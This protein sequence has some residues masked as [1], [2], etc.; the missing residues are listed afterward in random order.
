MR[1]TLLILFFSINIVSL[2][3]DN[4]FPYS[5]SKLEFLQGGEV[6]VTHSDTPNTNPLTFFVKPNWT[7][8]AE[9]LY[10][11]KGIKRQNAKGVAIG[12]SY[13]IANFP[14]VNSM[15]SIWKEENR[16]FVSIIDSNLDMQHITE[17][18]GN[19]KPYLPVSAYWIGKTGKNEY[20]FVINQSFYICKLLNEN[21]ISILNIAEDV[22][23]ATSL[24][25]D[26]DTTEYKAAFLVYQGASW[27]VNFLK[28]DNT[29]LFSARMPISDKIFLEPFK[30]QAA[31]ITYSKSYPNSLLKIVSPVRG[32][33]SEIWVKTSGDKIKIDYTG[34]KAKLFYLV[35]NNQQYYL[36]I[37]N[38]TKESQNKHNP[39]IEIPPELIEP[40]SIKIINN[41]IVAL[42]RNGIATF[43]TN[44]KI[45][46]IDFFPFGE[47]FSD[48]ISI[49]FLNNYLILSSK[50]A[51]LILLRDEHPW[52]YFNR[53]L[54]NFGRILLPTILIIIIIILFIFYRRQKALLE[55]VINLPATG[56]VF[57]I[58]KT[59]RLK[60][61]NSSGKKLLGI[62][63][64]IP[65]RRV[66]RY[67]CE[68]EHTKPITE[69]VDKAIATRDTFT[70]K[71]N[72]VKDNDMYEWIFNVISLRNATGGYRGFVLTGIDIT[73]QLERKRLS[74]WAQLAH[75]MQTNL[76]TIRLNAEQFDAEGDSNNANR[77]KKIIH[78]VGLL[79]Q[80]VRDV[81][82][83]GRSDTINKE[84]V[85]AYDICHEV[86]SEFDEAVFPHVSFTVE[87]QHYNIV[88]DKPKMIRAVRNAVENGIK[89]MQGKSGSITITNWWD[90]KYAF[91][92]VQDTGPG[93][94]EKT[95]KKML[96]PYFTT[97][98]KSGG[99]GIGTMIMQ[100]VM[101]LHGGEIKVKS[102]IGSGT[103]IIF[104][105]PNYSHNKK[106]K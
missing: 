68:F 97:A 10:S 30:Q 12:S 54:A 50:T 38:Y 71:L 3:A 17:I 98:K 105:L 76:S 7:E 69:L 36:K 15:L 1:L 102:E 48:K 28:K 44:G 9:S 46:S 94:D 41:T 106:K 33:I 88:C 74:N 79:I 24:Y 101:E 22:I 84:T 21:K 5:Y 65:M 16:F 61:A 85:D 32:V 67:Y 52:W 58:D 66:F 60:R 57:I 51:S 47:F 83:V 2:F 14:L 62:T 64:S 86:R 53:F 42:F 70:Q 72:I 103:Q 31:I 40:M 99:A 34:N 56:A 90:A 82:T 55:A 23:A 37:S 81:V 8:E 43:N 39:V 13:I 75:D 35:S 73:E 93:M 19:W 92:G 25:A 89:A 91:I 96:T 78:Q 80:R 18:P 95:M 104:C 59:G 100:H 87:A 11:W 63:D 29:V 20:G 49:S 45:L 26:I 77:R 6:I 4:T 27:I